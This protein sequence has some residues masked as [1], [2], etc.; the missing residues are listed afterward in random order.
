MGREAKSAVAVEYL[1]LT[2]DEINECK[3]KA[4]S[5]V[6]KPIT[7]K[8][9]GAE[10]VRRAVLVDR[11]T[12]FSQADA[13]RFPA[14]LSVLDVTAFDN[15]PD[16]FWVRVGYYRCRRPRG[17]KLTMNWGSQTTAHFP[18]AMWMKLFRKSGG[19]VLNRVLS[20]LRG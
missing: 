1:P 11:V 8:Y 12:T 2:V 19:P 20:Q 9:P 7:E 14:Y 15:A 4:M 3:R 13:P 17:G 5:R 10:G 16:E 6:G 18:V